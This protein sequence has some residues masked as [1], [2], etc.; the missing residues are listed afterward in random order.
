MKFGHRLDDHRR[1]FPAVIGEELLG[2]F[3][4]VVGQTW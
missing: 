2:E 1:Q 4:V 3:D